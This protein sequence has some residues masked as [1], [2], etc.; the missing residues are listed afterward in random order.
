M[1]WGKI[2]PPRTS[3]SLSRAFSNRYHDRYSLDSRGNYSVRAGERRSKLT[4]RLRCV[5]GEQLAVSNVGAQRRVAR[6]PRLRPGSLGGDTGACRARREA[7]AKRMSTE[8]GRIEARWGTRSL[9]IVKLLLLKGG[10]IAFVPTHSARSALS[11]ENKRLRFGVG[12]DDCA[13]RSPLPVSDPDVCRED[14]LSA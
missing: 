14:E 4:A 11:D 5:S 7:C 10:P 8:A 1:A 13:T 2:I 6:M 9:I 12:D 3:S